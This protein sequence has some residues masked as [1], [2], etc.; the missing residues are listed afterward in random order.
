MDI[1]QATSTN[2]QFDF[3]IDIVPRDELLVKN[4]RRAGSA[5]GASALGTAACSRGPSSASSSDAALV[6]QLGASASASGVVSAP[7]L[8]R[9]MLAQVHSNLSQMPPHDAAEPLAGAATAL[10]ALGVGANETSAGAAA[11]NT[12]AI[13]LQIPANLLASFGGLGAGGVSALTSASASGGEAGIGAGAGAQTVQ[14]L[15]QLP[16]NLFSAQAGLQSQAQ[17]QQHTQLV[18]PATLASIQIGG[19]KTGPA[20]PSSQFPTITIPASSALIGGA[21]VSK[22]ARSRNSKQQ[23]RAQRMI[24]DSDEEDDEDKPLDASTAAAVLLDG[25]GGRSRGRPSGRGRSRSPVAA[26]PHEDV[27]LE[28][29]PEEDSSVLSAQI[30][31]PPQSPKGAGARG[32]KRKSLIVS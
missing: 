15:L 11:G 4:S 26:Q 22:P 25:G 6:G 7:A 32:R 18:A 31:L 24:E 9:A 14:C 1:A 3:L 23:R 8:S 28:D 19:G 20:S 16:S 29:A 21:P 12:I 17:P 5:T 13:P 10:S 2:E 27:L 30:T